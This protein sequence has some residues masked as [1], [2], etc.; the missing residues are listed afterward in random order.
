[1]PRL[2]YASLCRVSAIISE[3]DQAV[4][5]HDTFC[6]SGIVKRDGPCEAL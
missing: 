1:M 3:D 4:A 6:L 2:M 5:M